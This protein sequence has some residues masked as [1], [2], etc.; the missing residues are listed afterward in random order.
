MFNKFEYII[1]HIHFIQPLWFWA[2]V[3]LLAILIL[4]YISNRENKKWQKLVAPHLRPYMFVK[5]SKSAFWLPIL[6]FVLCCSSIIIALA[7]P[8]WKMKDIPQGNAA[9][10]L[11]IGLDLSHSMLAEDIS[12]NR[13]ERMKLK[14]SDLLDANPETDIGLFAYSG[15][16]HIVVPFCNDY[17]IIRHHIENLHP[18]MM[19]VR[20]TNLQLAIE[21]VDSLLRKY[22]APST[23][24]LITDELSNEDAT[25]I[26]TFCNNSIHKVNIIPAATADGGSMPSFKNKRLTLKDKNGKERIA[27]PDMSVF[28]NTGL[29]N[30]VSITHLTLDKSDVESI[31]KLVRDNKSFTLKDK[32]DDEEWDNK[33]WWLILPVLLLILTWFRK[34]WSI[35]WMWMGIFLIQSCSPTDKNARWWYNNDYRA[36]SMMK[37]SLFEEAALTFES[38]QHKGTAY[39]KAQNYEAALEVFS[40]DS[41]ET[42]YYNKAITLIQ[43]GRLEEAQEAF[44]EVIALNPEMEVARQNLKRTQQMILQRDSIT[45][46]LEQVTQLD[47]NKK[48]EPLKEFQAK[49]KDKELSSDTEVDELPKDGKRITDEVE[50]QISKAE[51]LERPD[52]SLE[53]QATQKDAKNIMLKKISADPSEF[54]RRRFKFQKEKHYPYTKETSDI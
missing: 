13:L 46:P 47:Q 25:Y 31:A 16:P 8:A 1:K 15:T 33:G 9:A 52:E 35:F 36:Q 24:L 18:A 38:L 39:F 40:H 17:S 3:P 51:E 32:V 53:E 12:P 28:Q 5:G 44:N 11:L 49:T 30:K 20:G 14:I 7:G 23:L 6:D 43:M 10:S 2:F 27:K 34:G 48:S 50:T 41:T 45:V 54:L 42:R 21:L 19:P 22:D 4:V 26:E 37:D 29:N